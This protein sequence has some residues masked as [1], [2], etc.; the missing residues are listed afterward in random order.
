MKSEQ[1]VSVSKVS[2]V[3]VSGIK[4]TNFHENILSGGWARQEVKVLDI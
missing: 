2:G 4:F 1:K 3:S